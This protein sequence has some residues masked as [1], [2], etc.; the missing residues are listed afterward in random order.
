M[1]LNPGQLEALVAIA[2]HGS[3]DAAARRLH[4]T[5]SAVSQ[6]IRALETAAGQVLISRGTPCCPTPQG[7]WLVRLG[8][9]RLE[10][11]REPHLKL[12]SRGEG[13]GANQARG[14][15][16]NKSNL[17]SIHRIVGR[18]LQREAQS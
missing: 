11:G 7:E 12:A 5:P 16:T 4:I 1:D 17:H 8:R 3:F 9:G 14:Q 6:R 10:R 15:Q 18:T 2:D 13:R